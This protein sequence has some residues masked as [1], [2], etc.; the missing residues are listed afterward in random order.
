MFF[1]LVGH[2]NWAEAGSLFADHCEHTKPKQVEESLVQAL[3]WWRERK[4]SHEE[5]RTGRDWGG[6]AEGLGKRED[7]LPVVRLLS[8]LIPP[9]SRPSLAW[10]SSSRGY[11][12]SP[13]SSGED[14]DIQPWRKHLAVRLNY[15]APF[16]APF[17]SQKIPRP[18]VFL[19][20]SAGRGGGWCRRKSLGKIID[21]SLRIS[22]T[23]EREIK[24]ESPMNALV[25]KHL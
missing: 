25:T 17:L 11:I 14:W 21:R 24:A 23:G 19:P 5:K 3:R 1:H 12:V 8:S 6:S 4:Q 16:Q 10:F 7:G 13:P 22:Y 20:S 9:L 15:W 18:Q 2:Q